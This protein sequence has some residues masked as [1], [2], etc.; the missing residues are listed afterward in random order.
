V[1]DRPIE[2]GFGVVEGFYG[3]PWT[4]EA[5]LRIVEELARAGL[6]AYLWA[7]KSDPTHR[8]AWAEPLDRDALAEL[9]Y[10]AL[11]AADA[12]IELVHGIS[13]AGAARRAGL[14]GR[15]YQIDEER[16][17]ALRAR[18]DRVRAAGIERFALLFDDTW[19]TLL[20][21][22]ATFSLGRAHGDLAAAI[23][24]LGVRV[25]VVPAIYHRRATDLRSGALAY[26]RGIAVAVGRSVPVGWT[27]PNVFSSWISASDLEALEGATG[28]RLFVWNNA[29]AN[30]WLP[31]ATSVFGQRRQTERLSAGPIMNLSADVVTRSA[32]VLLNGAREAEVTRVALRAFGSLVR[33]PS[34]VDPEA[35]WAS[36]IHDVFG[37][38]GPVVREVLDRVRGHPLCAP[39]ARD[40]TLSEMVYAARRGEERA[41][42]ALTTEASR[43]ASLEARLIEALGDHPALPELGPTARA[44]SRTA[45]RL[46]AFASG[47]PDPEPSAREPWST[48]LDDS[49]ALLRA[50]PPGKRRRAG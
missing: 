44:L 19:P 31:L 32:G 45:R 10:L 38:A 16:L 48:D 5:R 13:P 49:L 39:H 20:P 4:H 27:G 42:R 11:R 22:A 12:G 50:A 24:S 14:L 7:P 9:E 21:D 28:L 47:A 6:N 35:A 37:D 36:A 8:A 26:L 41:R 34:H 43:L 15:R 30:D 25:L 2:V 1:T 33:D 3:R 46:Q 17:T 23:S 29:V 40:W 18:V